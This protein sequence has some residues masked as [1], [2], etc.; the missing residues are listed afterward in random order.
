MFFATCSVAEGIEHSD[1]LDGRGC[2]RYTGDAQRSTERSPPDRFAYAPQVG[3][4]PG[5]PPRQIT[6][7]INGHGI[8]AVPSRH[9]DYAKQFDGQLSPSASDASP[10]RSRI[11]SR[12]L[13][14]DHGSVY[15]HDFPGRTRVSAALPAQ[16]CIGHHYGVG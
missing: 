5:T 16:R 3:M 7:N 8:L 1:M 13:A 15:R 9:S 4:Q 6:G 2:V 11:G 14:L 10:H 12:S